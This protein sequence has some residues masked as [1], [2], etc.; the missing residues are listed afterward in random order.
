M[1]DR[2]VIRASD[3]IANVLDF[4]RG[5]LGGGIALSR[6]TD[7]PLQPVIEQVVA[8]LRAIALIGP[9]SATSLSTGR[10][11]AIRGGSGSLSRTCSETRSPI[12]PRI[13]PSGSRRERRKACSR[14]SVSNGG[15]PI[16]EVAMAKLF[17]HSFAATCTEISKDWVLACS[18]P[19]EIARAHGGDLSVR[20]SPEGTTFDFV[21]PLSPS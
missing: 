8:E 11:I 12:A 15:E 19:P 7:V 9:S 14:I 21:M 17:S 3:L 2:S 1:M 5:R 16:P 18:S 10:Q 13:G 20:S 6:G 4:A